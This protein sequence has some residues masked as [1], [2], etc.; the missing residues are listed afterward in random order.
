MAA[1]AVNSTTGAVSDAINNRNVKTHAVSSI[2]TIAI[3]RVAVMPLIEAAPGG[4]EALAPGAAE[5]ITAEL[6]SQVAVAGGWDPIPQQDVEAAMQ[7]MAPTTIAN[8]D[9]NALQL[10]HDASAAGVIYGTVVRYTERVGMDFGG[11]PGCGG[12]LAQ[13]RRSQ[14]QASRLDGEVCQVAGVLEPESV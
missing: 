13:V 12:V 3:N 14:E 11:K 10:G 7:K 8:L 2:K 6:Y 4:A 1:D 5:A 9:A